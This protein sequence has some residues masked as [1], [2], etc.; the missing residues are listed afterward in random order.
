MA[1]ANY[2][3]PRPGAEIAGTEV[4][5]KEGRAEAA[6][7]GSFGTAEDAG[8]SVWQARPCHFPGALYWVLGVVPTVYLPGI[9]RQTELVLLRPLRSAR[10]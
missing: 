1:E 2:K 9:R 5:G 8:L 6:A 7:P 10:V 4:A 3:R